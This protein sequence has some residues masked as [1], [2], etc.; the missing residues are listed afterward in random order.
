MPDKPKYKH[1]TYFKK[2]DLDNI[3]YSIWSPTL[4]EWRDVIED[5]IE[6]SKKRKDNKLA[7]FKLQVELL[8][9]IILVNDTIKAYIKLVKDPEHRKKEFPDVETDGTNVEWWEQEIKSFKI[10]LNAF[11]DIGDGIAWRV[12]NYDRSLIYNMCV[13]NENPGPLTINQGLIN[14]LLSFGD[15]SNDPDII[16]FVYHGITNFLLISDLTVVYRNGDINIMEIKSKSPHGKSW[17]E[18]LER[19]KEKAENIVNI[20]NESQGKSSKVDVKFRL[21]ENKPQTI[22]DQLDTLIKRA[23]DK[24]V[25]TQIFNSYLGIAIVNFSNVTDEISLEDKFKKLEKQLKK[26]DKDLLISPNSIE[27]FVFSPNR[28]PLSV[29]PFNSED[30][31]NILLGKYSVNYFFNVSQFIREIEKHGWKAFDI[32]HE[33]RNNTEPSLFSVKKD[34]LTMKIPPTLAAR[35]IYEGLAI[36]SIV[37]IFEDALRKGP[38][39]AENNVFYGYEKEKYLWK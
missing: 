39:H 22:L 29:H 6:I 2:S 19:Q 17:K 31:A 10:L 11:K 1:T 12:L 3:P 21:V 24:F 5:Y 28:A 16:N 37:Q 23:K 15:I 9:D 7:M 33:R 18:R 27:N 20:G 35:A 26:T 25:V 4:R 32:C 13:N 34:K 38:V 14:E 8:G 30:I 36:P